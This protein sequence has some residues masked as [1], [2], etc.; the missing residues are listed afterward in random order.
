MALGFKDFLTVDYLPGEP[1][2]IKYQDLRQ[3]RT[4]MGGGPSEAL[5]RQQ[6]I[7][8]ART[9]KRNKAK[10]E[11]GKKLAAKRV[12]SPEKIKQRAQKAARKLLFDKLARGIPKDELTYIKRGQ[13]EDKLN[14]PAM[15]AK[16]NKLAIKLVKE[17]RKKEIAKVSGGSGE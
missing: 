15:Q 17:I 13:I 16:I 3:K 7:Q 2:E 14:T 11:R 5:T 9:F 12:A 4:S 8:K 1:D 6:R 10:I